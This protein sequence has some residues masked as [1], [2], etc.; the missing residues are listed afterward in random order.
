MSGPVGRRTGWTGARGRVVCESVGLAA[1]ENAG[2]VICGA[3]VC[4]TCISKLRVCALIALSV[5][6]DGAKVF[7]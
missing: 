4:G 5:A 7:E 6:P 3:R 1:L 2:R